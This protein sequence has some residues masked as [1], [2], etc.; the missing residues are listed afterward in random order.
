MKLLSFVYFSCLCKMKH[1]V[2]EAQR[3]LMNTYYSDSERQVG[4][5]S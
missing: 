4:K 1:V 5:E 3:F 2:E